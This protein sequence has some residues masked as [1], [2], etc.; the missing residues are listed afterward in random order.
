MSPG[1]AMPW[2]EKTLHLGPAW[3]GSETT[4][5]TL[6]LAS[7]YKCELGLVPC[8]TWASAYPFVSLTPPSNHSRSRSTKAALRLRGRG[9][10]GSQEAVEAGEAM[11]AEGGWLFRLPE[12]RVHGGEPVRSMGKK[13]SLPRSG[14]EA[15]EQG[16]PDRGGESG[17][18]GWI[19]KD[20]IR[21]T[22]GCFSNNTGGRQPGPRL[23]LC[24]RKEDT[25]S[26]DT[27]KEASSSIALNTR[28]VSSH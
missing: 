14:R 7:Y 2:I 23:M 3:S 20:C 12:G 19:R 18:G 15:Q 5:V 11:M 4:G 22:W 24:I 17:G 27:A 28:A 25:D 1:D 21:E 26:S 16:V 9:A 8:P 13:D 10:E 6:G